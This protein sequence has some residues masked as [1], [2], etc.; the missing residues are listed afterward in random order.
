MGN[1]VQEIGGAVER[2]DD[3]TMGAVGAFDHAALLHEETVA[4][5]GPGQLGIEDLLGAGIGGADEIGRPFER[6]LE[7]LDL[8][9]IARQAAARFAGSGEHDGHQGGCGHG[10]NS[11]SFRRK[12]ESRGACSDDIVWIPAF[13][14]MTPEAS[15]RGARK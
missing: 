7:L 11:T 5:P 9:E 3:P 8:A 15:R 6:N 1:A 10:F 2:I 13:A 12:P 14:G 4:G